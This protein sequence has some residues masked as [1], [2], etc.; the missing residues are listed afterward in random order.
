MLPIKSC[1]NLQTFIISK[2]ERLEIDSEPRTLGLQTNLRNAQGRV[3]Q[4]A[5]ETLRFHPHGQD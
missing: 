5:T 1:I 4:E 3:A 2:R